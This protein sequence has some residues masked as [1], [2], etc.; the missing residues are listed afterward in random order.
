MQLN[1]I[2][3]LWYFDSWYPGISLETVDFDQV[4]YKL[5]GVCVYKLGFLKTTCF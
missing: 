1:H 3:R 5:L 2:N 4:V